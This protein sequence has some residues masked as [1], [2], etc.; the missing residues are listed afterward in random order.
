MATFVL[1]SLIKGGR[2]VK[3]IIGIT[4]C[5]WDYWLINISIVIACCYLSYM[6]L[7]GIIRKF[8]EKK[9]LNIR[10]EES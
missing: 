5:K 7:Q 8:K 9:R 3:S 1:L 4:Y 10:E 2:T 6:L